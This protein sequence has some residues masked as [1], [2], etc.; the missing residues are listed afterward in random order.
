MDFRTAALLSMTGPAQL[1]ELEA[2]ERGA[3]KHARRRIDRALDA[4]WLQPV[5]ESVRKMLA[6][7]AAAVAAIAVVVTAT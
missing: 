3:R 5:A 1:L 7:E 2:L 6:D 4:T